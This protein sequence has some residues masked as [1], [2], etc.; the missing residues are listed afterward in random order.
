MPVLTSKMQMPPARL[1]LQGQD[2]GESA[3]LGFDDGAGLMGD[4]P[5]QLGVGLMGVAQVACAVRGVQAGHGQARRVSDVVQ[6][7][8]CLME[9]GVGAQNRCQAA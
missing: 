8:G 2:V 6:P 9:I 7:P 4:Q 3:L 5:A 1:E